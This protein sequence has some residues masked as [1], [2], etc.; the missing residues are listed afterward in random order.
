[1]PT[2]DDYVALCDI[3]DKITHKLCVQT[4]LLQVPINTIRSIIKSYYLNQI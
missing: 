4:Y 1:M 3:F 2:S